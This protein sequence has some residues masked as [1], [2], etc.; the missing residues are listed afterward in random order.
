MHGTGETR[1]VGSALN[2]EEDREYGE[3]VSG[4]RGTIKS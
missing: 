4:A 3:W 1:R 2:G